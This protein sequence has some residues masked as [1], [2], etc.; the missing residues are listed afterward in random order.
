MLGS[1]S[2]T[3]VVTTLSGLA[4]AGTIL[5]RSLVVSGL[6]GSSSGLCSDGLDFLLDDRDL[7]L[8]IL[9]V[10]VEKVKDIC[11]RHC[12]LDC[13]KWKVVQIRDVNSLS[14]DRFRFYV[15][16]CFL[17]PDLFSSMVCEIW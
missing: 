9:S 3:T 14:Y 7:D 17:H 13:L 5:A 12:L 15:L 10:V 6:G 4:T 8:L 16:F 2:L 11:R 1:G